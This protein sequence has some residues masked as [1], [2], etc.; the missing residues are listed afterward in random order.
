MITIEDVVSVCS[1]M[2]CILTEE[3]MQWIVDNYAHFEMEDSTS[4]WSD[5][6]EDIIFRN[7]N[8]HIK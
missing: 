1:R 2:N 3:K 8:E 4:N 7:F 6:V 5:I